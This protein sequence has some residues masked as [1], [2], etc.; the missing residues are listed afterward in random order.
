MESSRGYHAEIRPACG[1][2]VRDGPG[3]GAERCIAGP[4]NPGQAIQKLRVRTQPSAIPPG[5]Q[6]ACRRRRVGR[7]IGAGVDHEGS[8]NSDVDAILKTRPKAPA[9][10]KPAGNIVRVTTTEELKKALQ[11][12]RREHDPSGGGSTGRTACSCGTAKRS[13]FAAKAAS[14]RRSSSTA[15]AWRWPAKRHWALA[16]RHARLH[17]RR[18]QATTSTMACS[19]GDATC[20]GR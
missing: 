16:A 13:P 9:L 3:V 18:H 4:R 8:R 7:A 10:P 15:K 6:R 14:V 11:T 1:G 2:C 5:K 19:F 20:S 17:H 12:V